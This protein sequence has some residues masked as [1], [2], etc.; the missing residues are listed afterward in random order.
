[1]A[2]LARLIEAALLVAQYTF[3]AYD[4]CRGVDRIHCVLLV[5][6][7]PSEHFGGDRRIGHWFGVINLVTLSRFDEFN[8]RQG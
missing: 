7:T 8:W 1:M 5:V 4:G 3:V 2:L 6:V